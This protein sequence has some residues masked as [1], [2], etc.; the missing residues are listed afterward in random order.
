MNVSNDVMHDIWTGVVFL[1][2]QRGSPPANP[3]RPALAGALP[4]HRSSIQHARVPERV[5]MSSRFA[6]EP[7]C[8]VRGVVI[9]LHHI[10][11]I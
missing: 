2:H 4:G 1:E 9:T 3:Q 8:Q 11:M 10:S 5:S 7:T 6:H